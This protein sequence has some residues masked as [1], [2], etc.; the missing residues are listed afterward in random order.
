MIKFYSNVPDFLDKVLLRTFLKLYNN[1]SV[2]E[3]DGKNIL[4]TGYARTALEIGMKHLGLQQGDEILCS[5]TVCD[6][7][8]TGIW[9]QKLKP[10]FYSI[11]DAFKIDWDSCKNLISKKSKGFLGI[12]YFG[13]PME[14]E[15]AINFCDNN[16][17]KFIEDN[18]HGY[19]SFYKGKYLGW[20]GDIGIASPRKNLAL[21]NGGM[22]IYDGVMQN[23]E[24]RWFEN[25]KKAN[26]K[27][28]FK[29]PCIVLKRIVSNYINISKLSERDI[30]YDV[31]DN[32]EEDFLD[33]KLA[34]PIPQIAKIKDDIAKRQEIFKIWDDIL[35]KNTKLKIPALTLINDCTN[36]NPLEYVAYAKN[37]RERDQ[38]INWGKIHGI[39]VRP[40]PSLPKILRDHSNALDRWNRLILFPINNAYSSKSVRKFIEKKIE[41]F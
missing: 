21:F 23:D 28:F 3:F 2:K 9:R 16:G 5:E 10:L 33:Y 39:K 17:L 37:K 12:D 13:F 36:V 22:L 4:Y 24:I 14:I 25:L 27:S 29:I 20:Y 31:M 38:W 6:V 32:G 35:K 18:A 15:Q 11:N 8:L 26:I 1:H 34:Q 19:G 30:D 7:V 41:L 40:W